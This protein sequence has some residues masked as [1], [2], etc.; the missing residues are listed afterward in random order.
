MT[1]IPFAYKDIY[2]TKGLRTTC[3]SRMLENFV[4]P[5]DA[6]VVEQF[7]AAGAVPLGKCNMDEFAMG[8]SNENSYFGPVRNPWDRKRGARRLVR[9]LGRGG[10]RAH[11]ARPRPAPTPAARCASRRRSPACAA[12]EPTYGLVSR[13]G[14]IAFASSLDQA[15]PIA[16]SAADLALLMNVMAGLDARDSTSARAAEG[17][18]HQRA[19]GCPSKGLRIG[20]PKEYF[21]DGLEPGV[22]RAVEAAVAWFKSQGAQPVAVEL[23]HTKLCG[24]R[25]T[26]SSRRP[27]PRRTCR[28]ST[29]CAT[30]IARRSTAT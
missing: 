10:R 25:S 1:G 26:T 2:C 30:A 23:P 15:G 21:G 9:R 19:C 6:H 12:C 13:Y 11:G 3:G 14:L 24:R 20:L 5:Y 4:S 7:S 17:G 29:A 28:A 27:K 22:R 16:R 18:L 8:S